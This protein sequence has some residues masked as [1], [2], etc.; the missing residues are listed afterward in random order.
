MTLDSQIQ[1]ILFVAGKPVAL[2]KLAEWCEAEPADV[3]AALDELAAR[4]Q[5][6]GL[7][8]LRHGAEAELVTHPGAAALVRQV[9]KEEEQ[10]E[11]TRPSLEA[12]SILAYRGPLTRPELEQIRGV[13][14]ALIL[15]NLILRGLVEM[16]SEGP[17]G[18]P[19]YAVTADFLRHL[20]LDR[21]ESL[22]DYADLHEEPVVEQV[23]KE[24]A[25]PEEK[26]ANPTLEV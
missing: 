9:I 5:D 4:L 17:L 19:T 10:G 1:A 12:L 25:E 18:Q 2:K 8:L 22:P 23:L 26:P 24:L 20:G 6:S 11:L 3:K 16:K 7:Q 13:Q 21:L 14:S 15:R